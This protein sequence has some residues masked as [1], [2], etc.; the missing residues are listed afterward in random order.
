MRAVQAARAVGRRLLQGPQAHFHPPPQPRLTLGADQ[1]GRNLFFL[2]IN[3]HTHTHTHPGQSSAFVQSL[4]SALVG[5]WGPGLGSGLP[6]G[7]CRL[8]QG[9]PPGALPWAPLP[10]QPQELI[11]APVSKYSSAWLSLRSHMLP[12]AWGGRTGAS[13]W[14]PLV[15]VPDKHSQGPLLGTTRGLEPQP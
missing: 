4:P 8:G 3:T 11:L 12:T 1:P 10:P 6:H 5:Q 9:G 2:V 7:D 15:R 14:L 13:E